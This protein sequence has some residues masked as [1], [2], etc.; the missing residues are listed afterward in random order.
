MNFDFVKNVPRF[1]QLFETCSAAEQ[2]A[3]PLPAQSCASARTALEYIVTLIYRSV[4]EYEDGGRT[5]FEKMNDDRFI[6][7]INDETILSAM[8]TVRKNG[9]LGAHGERLSPQTACD[10]LE[11]LHYIIGEVFINKHSKTTRFSNRP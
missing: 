6:N 11:Q 7:Y 5:L 1:S 10:T 8:H 4:A 9:N 2:L 3:R